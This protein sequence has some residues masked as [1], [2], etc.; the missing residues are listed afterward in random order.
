LGVV[1]VAA[2]YLISPSGLVGRAEIGVDSLSVGS[3]S[4][5][6]TGL[7]TQSVFGLFT[8]TIAAS[9]SPVGLATATGFGVVKL[10]ILVFGE[11]PDERIYHVLAESRVYQI[12]YE[13]RIYSID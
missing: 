12:Q 6:P 13:N 7:N 3:I 1:G 4:I 2:V 10:S 5:T 11:I 8:A 9:L